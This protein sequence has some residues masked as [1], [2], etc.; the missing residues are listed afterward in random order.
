M[1]FRYRKLPKCNITDDCWDY[2]T[3]GGTSGYFIT[4]QLLYFI[5]VDHVR[6]LV[7]FQRYH[8][9]SDIHLSNIFT[10]STN[11]KL[12]KGRDGIRCG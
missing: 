2:M 1:D 6:T 3:Q 10:L 11:L 4:H 9:L 7:S 12:Q 5:V 8:V